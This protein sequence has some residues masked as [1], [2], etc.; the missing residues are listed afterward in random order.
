MK[1]EEFKQRILPLLVRLFAQPDRSIRR[2]LLEGISQ[3]GDM[4]TSELVETKVYPAVV[5]G[6]E[7]QM[8]R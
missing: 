7:D 5:N 6:F 4:L 8:V 1:E 2:E 3:Y